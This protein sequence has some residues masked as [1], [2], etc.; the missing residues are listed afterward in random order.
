MD[1][2]KFFSIFKFT[3]L[4]RYATNKIA[5]FLGFPAAL[6]LLADSEY[7][8]S[9][10]LAGKP[11]KCTLLSVQLPFLGLSFLFAIVGVEYI[12]RI[13]PKGTHHYRNL[14]KP[15]ELLAMA[16]G[17]GLSLRDQRGLGYNPLTQRF[18]L[19]SFMGVG[20]LLAMQKQA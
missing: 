4:V 15:T 5:H 7:A 18:R 14:I 8:S 17:T 3:I 9:S 1:S 16:Q 12:L 13:L 19:H 11:K 10:R 2:L 20:Y 6:L